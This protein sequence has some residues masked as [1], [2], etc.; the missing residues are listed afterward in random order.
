VLH[1]SE[2][3]DGAIESIARIVVSIDLDASPFVDEQP[4]NVVSFRGPLSVQLMS[5]EVSWECFVR[6]TKQPISGE[7]IAHAREHRNVE[8]LSS[9]RA[10]GNVRKDLWARRKYKPMSC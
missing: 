3:C 9:Y 10:R 4:V 1:D 8:D 2:R 7:S 5:F 6:A